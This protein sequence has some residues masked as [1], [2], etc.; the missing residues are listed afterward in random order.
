MASIAY[1]QFK[2]DLASGVY[3][4][5]S[6]TVKVLLVGTGYTPD[7][8]HQFVSDITGGPNYELSGTNYVAG[9]SGAGRKTLASTTVT[10]DNTNDLAYYDA[11]DLTWTAINAGTAR[12]AALYSPNTTDANSK[13]LMIIQFPADFVSNGGDGVLQWNSGGIAQLT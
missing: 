13:L 2:A 8:D 9:F 3:N 12:Y 11:A 1:N 5:T 6:A 7:P 10:K 4:L